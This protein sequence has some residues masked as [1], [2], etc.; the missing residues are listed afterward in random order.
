VFFYTPGAPKR[1]LGALADQSYSTV[2][3]AIAAL[4]EGLP[5]GCARGPDPEG[6]YAY[7]RV[8]GQAEA[9]REPALTSS[10]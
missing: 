3:A 7:A 1:E 4:L 10:F 2:E 5:E 6:P 8:D 9:E